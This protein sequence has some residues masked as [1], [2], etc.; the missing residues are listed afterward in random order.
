VPSAVRRGRGPRVGGLRDRSCGRQQRLA[1][2]AV[3]A[4]RGAGTTAIVW[5]R[6]GRIV[7]GMFGREYEG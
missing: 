5:S 4:V 1:G 2:L 7:R 6:A 3:V